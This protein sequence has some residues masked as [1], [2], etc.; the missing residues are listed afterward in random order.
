MQSRKR[1]K[2]KTSAQFGQFVMLPVVM[3]SSSSEADVIGVVSWKLILCNSF[4]RMSR[5][6]RSRSADPVKSE[7]FPQN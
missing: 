3:P 1:V 7:D 6:N 5:M 4:L 2:D